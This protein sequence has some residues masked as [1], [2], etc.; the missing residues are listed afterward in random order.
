V[1]VAAYDGF[2]FTTGHWMSVQPT[3]IQYPRE[4]D[5]LQPAALAVSSSSVTV[6]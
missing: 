5:P 2:D 6:A 3:P 4:A 1:T